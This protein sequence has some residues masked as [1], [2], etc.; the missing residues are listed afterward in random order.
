MTLIDFYV[1]Q[2]HAVADQRHF[3]CR[4]IEKAVKQ[5]NRVMVATKDAE[6]SKIL[7]ETLWSFRANSFI[8]HT[9][10]G[11]ALSQESTVLLSHQ[12]DDKSH[13]DVLVNLKLTVPLHFSRFQRLVEIVVKEP[14]VL[15]NSRRNYAFYKQRG[16]P[17][18]THKL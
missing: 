2:Q 1:L 6:E 11:D 7:D 10:Q 5:G 18:N 17:I 9:V 14:S 4:L 16:Y 3:A 15:D 8:P 12:E 13:H